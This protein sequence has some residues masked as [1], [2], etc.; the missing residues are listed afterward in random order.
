MADSKCWF[1]L[2]HT[3]Y[4][5]P[6]FPSDG[7]VGRSTG[8]L[9]LGH[10]I[11]DLKHLDTVINREGPLAFPPDMPAYLTQ[12]RD[13]SCHL[14]TN[15]GVN[16]SAEVGI[17]IALAAG[18]TVKG[19]ANSAFQRSVSNFSTFKSADIFII[20][21]TP[22]Y[23][24]D[25]LDTEEVRKYVK[26]H[27]KLG[28]WSLFM[29]TGIIIARGGAK[30]STSDNSTRGIGGGPGAE[31]P[32]I[33]EVGLGLDFSTQ[34]ELFVASEQASD[35]VWAIRVA[36]I[37][38]GFLDREWSHETFSQG[39]TYGLGDGV[40]WRQTETSEQCAKAKG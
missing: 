36:K 32:G 3:H 37:S 22:S 7:G 40:H 24:E 2:R 10:L 18:V 4:P 8:P 13:F 15:R 16:T 5:P 1:V 6:V 28:T 30:I 33:A 21:V 27:S 25:S 29:I 20:Q 14:A 31:L 17:P 39:A 26:K 11:P 9:C 23:I 34:K 35:F 38:K 12:M 19:S